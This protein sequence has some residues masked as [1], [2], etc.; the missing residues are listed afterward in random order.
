M[1]QPPQA[2]TSVSARPRVVFG[3]FLLVAVACLMIGSA[4]QSSLGGELPPDG[5]TANEETRWA[6][7]DALVRLGG[8]VALVWTVIAVVLRKR[9]GLRLSTAVGV[10]IGGL[11]TALF[12]AYLAWMA[13]LG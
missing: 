1:G 6:W 7:G 5:A 12:L 3:L 4:L 13:F 8:A 11:A 10:A 9:I 2:V